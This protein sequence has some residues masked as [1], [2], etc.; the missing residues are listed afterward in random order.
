MTLL[1]VDLGS[2]HLKAGIFS[3]NGQLLGIASCDHQLYPDEWGGQV[4]HPQELIHNILT[5]IEQALAM[6]EARLQAPIA[7]AGIGIASMAESGLLVDAATGEAR[8][9]IIPWFDQRSQPQAQRLHQKDGA[10]Q[11]FPSRGIHPT[12]KSSLA[13]LMWLQ[14]QQPE[15]LSGAR[16]QR[17]F[18]QMASPLTWYLIPLVRLNR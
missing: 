16:W 14:E 15:V 4:Y 12:F 13:K 2:T 1:G 9:A 11:R 8:T 10:R 3:T 17:L 5:I 6:A 18:S 7:L